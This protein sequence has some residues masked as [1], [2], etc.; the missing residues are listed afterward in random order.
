MFPDRRN[1]PIVCLLSRLRTDMPELPEVE[2][3]RRGIEPWVLKQQVS[4]VVAKRAL[5]AAA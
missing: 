1:N 5:L 4:G 3:S 2:T